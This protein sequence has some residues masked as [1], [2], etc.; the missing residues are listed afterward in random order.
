MRFSKEEKYEMKS[1]TRIVIGIFF[2]AISI[3]GSLRW[4]KA[5][6]ESGGLDHGRSPFQYDL[7]YMFLIALLGISVVLVMEGKNRF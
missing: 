1:M 4:K 3:L 5:V 2:L 7:P 6:V